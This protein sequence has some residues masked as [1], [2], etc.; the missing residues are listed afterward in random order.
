MPNPLPERPDLQQLRRRAKELR[1]AAR[2]G[3]PAAVTRIA[4]QHPAA[5]PETL[6]LAAAQF[7]L[8]REHGYPSWPA[9]RAVI[10]AEATS[11]SWE[12]AFLAAS[13]NTGAVDAAALLAHPP[14]GAPRSLRVAAVLGDSDIT[15]ETLRHDRAAALAVD[16]DRGWP[17][18]LYACYSH[19][20]HLDPD[21]AVG[22][23]EVVRLLLAAGASANT[24]DGGRSRLRSALR[25]TVETGKP[26]LTRLLLTA[27]ADPDLGQPI[28]EAIAG[29]DHHTLTLLLHHGARITRTWAMGAA[30][31]HDD[32]DAAKRL[33]DTLAT[34]GEDPGS[35]AGAELIDAARTG[36]VPLIDVLLDAGAN[37]NSADDRGR[38]ALRVAVRA[39]RGDTARRLVER[40]ASDDATTI[41]RF[42]GA[43]LHADRAATDR[44]L[45]DEPDLRHRLSDQDRATI[46]D[47]A[48]AHPDALALMLTYG[49]PTDARDD[50]GEQPLHTAAYHGNPETVRLLLAAGADIDARDHRFRATPLAFATIGSGEHDGD[51]GDWVTTVR[52]LLDAG[53][54]RTGVWISD[55]PP[56]APVAALL[57]DY[58]ITPERPDTGPAD[59]DQAPTPLGEDILSDIARHLA[60]V[61]EDRDLDLLDPLLH[62]DVQWT[63]LCHTK[64]DVLAWFRHA[65]ADGTTPT[66]DSIDI[67]R[68][69]VIL[70]V[71]L[72][73]PADTARPA[74]PQH[75]CPVFSI[76]DA[77]I[78]DIRSYP[79]RDAALARPGPAAAP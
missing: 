32:P 24:N 6:S 53:A 70:G 19:W 54:D 72:T 45:T 28:V 23:L 49:F 13:L 36:S 60:A 59:T 31:F 15:A 1:D 29:G 10:D 34:R 69:A 14:T 17:P 52:L 43:C 48:A 9:L 64:A 25:G 44:L 63:G 11:R 12:T 62:P 40:G 61:C 46:L 76:R 79:D 27:G 2:A 41:D 51:P 26:A 8:A 5:R 30:V 55:K 37:P 71:T 39:G 50:Q 58:G 3:D 21:R 56:S 42:L 38:S 68:D 67:D 57:T 16:Q 22:L 18:I 77:L 47:A 66:L 33:L 74:P 35:A 75:L 7:V 20:H 4:A 73:R 78:V 65:L